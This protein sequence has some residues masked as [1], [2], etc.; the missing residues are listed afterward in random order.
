[1][2]STRF[3]EIEIFDEWQAL[4]WPVNL[5]VIQFLSPYGRSHE[6]SVI[7]P[8]PCDILPSLMMTIN[9]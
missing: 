3:Q 9:T 7:H 2:I 8:T 4:F 1:M 6:V 5:R